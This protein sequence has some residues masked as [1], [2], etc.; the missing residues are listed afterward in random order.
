MCNKLH[1]F[2]YTFWWVLTYIYIH[3]TITT[4]KIINTSIPPKFPGVSCIPC[5]PL[6]VPTY[7]VLCSQWSAC[8][9]WHFIFFKYQILSERMK[10]FSFLGREHEGKSLKEV[11]ISPQQWQHC[12]NER[13]S[14]EER[15]IFIY[16]PRKGSYPQSWYGFWRI[17]HNILCFILYF[18]IFCSWT[19]LTQI[20]WPVL[21]LPV[22]GDHLWK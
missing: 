3:E 18:M 13:L 14:S 1:I 2:K 11:P 10:I 15:I 16:P 19:L 8:S 7:P 17:D 9:K 4:I 6:H 22:E 20:N 21:Q 12:R 5:L